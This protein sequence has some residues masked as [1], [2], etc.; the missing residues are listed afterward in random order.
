MKWMKHTFL[1]EK[2]KRNVPIIVGQANTSDKK[3]IF[4]IDLTKITPKKLPSGQKFQCACV[5]CRDFALQKVTP[6]A[7]KI[8]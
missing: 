5:L 8:Y 3:S 7:I 6:F 1:S 2:K 4:L